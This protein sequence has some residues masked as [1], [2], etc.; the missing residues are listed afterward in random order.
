MARRRSRHARNTAEDFALARLLSIAGRAFTH[1]DLRGNARA[2]TTPTAP[3]GAVVRDVC[4]PP[5]Q[6]LSA[7]VSLKRP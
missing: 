5:G 7:L 4:K 3:E 6:R 1:N 2:P